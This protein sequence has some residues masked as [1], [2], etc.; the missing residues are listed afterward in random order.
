MK[1]LKIT[2]MDN[3]YFYVRVPE[4]VLNHRCP[5]DERMRWVMDNFNNVKR[6]EWCNMPKHAL[7]IARQKNG[8]SIIFYTEIYPA[9]FTS[10]DADSLDSQRRYAERVSK[11]IP[12]RIKQMTTWYVM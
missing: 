4:N 5:D 2:F 12:G 7:L 3:L 11:F 10:D 6:I 9:D 8:N 1:H